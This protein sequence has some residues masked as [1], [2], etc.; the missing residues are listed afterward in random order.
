MNSGD[1]S[2][3]VDNLPKHSNFGILSLTIGVLTVLGTA[4]IISR[5]LFQ[6]IFSAAFFVILFGTL[7]LAILGIGLGIGALIQ[8]DSKKT[9]GI[10]GCA[11]NGFVLLSIG[12]L[13]IFVLFVF[14]QIGPGIPDGCVF[15]TAKAW[16]D[17][18]ENGLW[19]K[20]EAPLAGVEFV[21]INNQQEYRFRDRSTSDKNG[22]AELLTFPYTCDSLHGINLLV[23]ATPPEGYRATTPEQVI[24]SGDEL[25][26]VWGRTC[27]FGFTSKTEP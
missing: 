9:L 10:L 18:N 26:H 22:E 20:S 6:S 7:L 15:G 24:I 2:S 8:K 23:Q 11:L 25:P 13:F 3:P 17:Q 16:D 21:V 12:L 5:F 1:S 19:D 14:I 4:G 27:F